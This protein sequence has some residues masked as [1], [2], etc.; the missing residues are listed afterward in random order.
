MPSL[1]DFVGGEAALHLLEDR[2]YTL[3]LT[4]ELLQPMFGAGQPHHVDHLTAFTAECFG[5]PTRFSDEIGFRQLIDVHRGLRITEAQRQR[6]VQLYL[7]ALYDV[8]VTD[9]PTPEERSKSTSSSAPESPCRILTPA[10]EGGNIRW[11]AGSRRRV[12]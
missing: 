5:G 12:R 6:F 4:D 2:L 9:N 8:E 10:A 1:Y 11:R 7:E 3:V